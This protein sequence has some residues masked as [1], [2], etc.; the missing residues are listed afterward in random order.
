MDGGKRRFGDPRKRLYLISAII[1]MA[2][3]L[4]SAFIY[5]AAAKGPG[6]GL[7]GE[8]GGDIYVVRPEDSKMYRHDLEVYG[9]K[10]NVLIDKFLRWFGGLWHG[11]SLALTVACITA[12]AAVGVFLIARHWPFAPDVHTGRNRES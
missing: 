4:T 11:E 2:G 1:M 6:N 7:Y 5:L 12:L 9:G 8:E 3:L 10:A